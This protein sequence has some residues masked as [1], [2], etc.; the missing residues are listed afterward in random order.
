MFAFT[1]RTT[2]H[3]AP[4]KVKN[5]YFF[6]QSQSSQRIEY[7]QLEGTCNDHLGYLRAD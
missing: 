7:F 6:Q 1:L 3:I 2:H 5:T 4:R